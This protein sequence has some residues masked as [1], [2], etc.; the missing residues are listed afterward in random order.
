MM[1]GG[2]GDVLGGG[3]PMAPFA[4]PLGAEADD[5]LHHAEDRIADAL[6]LLLELGEIDV[7]DAALLH[8][9]ARGL[10]AG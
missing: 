4:E 2:V 8:D 9:L 10:L 6:G 1:V 5:L 3:A 7:L